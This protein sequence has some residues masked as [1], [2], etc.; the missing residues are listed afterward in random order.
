ML[1]KP[2]R[3]KLL[4]YSSELVKRMHSYGI[5]NRLPAVKSIAL[6]PCEVSVK[7]MATAYSAFAKHSPARE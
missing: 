3:R 1:M 7:E 2:V 5:T 6:G 4:V